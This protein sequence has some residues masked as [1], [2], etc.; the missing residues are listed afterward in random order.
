[1]SS[2]D[3]APKPTVSMSLVGPNWFAPS[4]LMLAT[5]RVSG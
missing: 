2:S 5:V 1:M 3:E 4:M